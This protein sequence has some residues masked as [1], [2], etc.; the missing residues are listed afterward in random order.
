MRENEAFQ[1]GHLTMG[2]S[3]ALG[4]LRCGNVRAARIG[5]IG[6]L[7]ENAD[8]SG[9]V[10]VRGWADD[11]AE[12]LRNEESAQYLQ[13]F[14]EQRFET[15][16][17]STDF[18]GSVID[19]DGAPEACH[20]WMLL[21]S[22]TDAQR[23]EIFEFLIARHVEETEERTDTEEHQPATEAEAAAEYGVTR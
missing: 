16:D 21:Q 3:V 15:M 8:H 4:H 7:G 18:A 6:L 17:A 22:T 2:I 13:A 12:E 1:T 10:I 23:V 9:S 11:R 5:L 20:A 19:E 14:Y